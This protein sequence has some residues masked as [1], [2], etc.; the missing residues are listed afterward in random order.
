[1]I[2]DNYIIWTIWRNSN[3]TLLY[4]DKNMVWPPL[5]L[6]VSCLMSSFGKLDKKYDQCCRPLQPFIY[7][8]V[9]GWISITLKEWLAYKMKCF[10]FCLL[11][12]HKSIP[13]F[14]FCFR[15]T[16][17]LSFF[18]ILYFFS[19]LHFVLDKY[20]F[21]YFNF[22]FRVLFCFDFCSLF[23]LFCLSICLSICLFVCL[24]KI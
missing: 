23:F 20:Y 11:F 21:A 13:F 3:V 15:F 4:L 22:L 7:F 24:S 9:S 1:M 14:C 10:I 8:Y 16:F 2:N 17:F 12:V 18:I 19:Y 6:I 5:N